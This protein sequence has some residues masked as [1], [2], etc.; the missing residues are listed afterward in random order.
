MKSDQQVPARL[1][2]GFLVLVILGIAAAF[3]SSRFGASARAR[4]LPILGSLPGF[5]LTDRSGRAVTRADLEGRVSVVDFIFTSCTAQCP[6]VTA[7]MAKLQTFAFSRWPRLRL[8]SV[9]VDPENDSRQVLAAYAR[10]AG[11]DPERWWFLTGPPA[12]V[13]S[14]I[15]DGFHVAGASRETVDTSP[16]AIL[17][18][19]S[20]VLV[21]SRARIRG[22]YQSTDPEEMAQLR[23]DLAALAGG[24]RGILSLRSLPHLNA[25]LNAVSFLFLIA[26]YRFIRAKKVTAHR[27]CM[28][29]A[30]GASVLFF[31]SYITYHAQVGSVRFPGRGW[32]RPAY[33]SLLISHT[34]L[35]ATVPFLAGVTLY[36]ALRGNF[37]A[38]RRIARWTLPVW[39]Y[40]SLTGVLVYL[41]LY[42]VYRAGI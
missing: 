36:R 1:L 18:S 20:L 3:L 16:G 10:N 17:H 6:R 34:L 21:D 12:A 35:A 29:C 11:A 31:V 38:H 30:C 7:E 39:A 4:S 27:A 28:L 23:G 13:D 15:R 33:F 24:G 42:W 19:V 8:I 32:V 5:S 26:G 2:W 22:Y 14:L 40:V 9:T 41:V 37:S 25:L